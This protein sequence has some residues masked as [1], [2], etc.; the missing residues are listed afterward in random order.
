MLIPVHREVPVY[1]IRATMHRVNIIEWT[2]VDRRTFSLRLT[3][4]ARGSREEVGNEAVVI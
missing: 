2:I 3:R 4:S 1:A